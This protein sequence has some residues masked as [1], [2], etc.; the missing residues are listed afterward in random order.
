MKAETL[1]KAILQ[2]AMQGKLVEQDPNDEPASVLLERIKAEK[3]QLIKDGKIKKEK[4][5][6]PISEDE[7]PYELPNGW[8]WVRFNDA[9]LYSTDYVANGSFASLRN[10][11][12][13]YKTENY[14]ILVKT[15]DFSTNFSTN[16]TYID[17]SSYEYLSKSKLYGG[18]L[19]LSNIGASI[20]KV[21]IIP[22][23]DR[24]MSIAPNSIIVKC[25][26]PLMTTFFKYIILSSYGQDLLKS[27]TAGTA[28]PKFSKTQLR[29]SIIPLPPLAEQ[30]RIVEKLEQILPL[31]EEYGKNEEK[32]SKLNSTLPD[33]IK[34]SILQHAVQGKLVPQNPNEESASEL[35]KRIKAEK[36][37]LIKDGKIKKEKPLP[38]IT[39]DEIPFKIPSSWEWCRVND[40]GV[41]K[42]GP[43]GSALTKKIFVPKGN[44]TVKVYEQKNAI[45]KDY[46]LGEYYI[47]KEYYEKSMKGFTVSSGDIIVSCAGTIGET[48]VMPENIELG[49]I[50][51]ALMRMTITK[52]IDLKYFLMY[53]DIILKR[54]SKTYSKGSAIKNIPPFEIFK[55]MLVPLPPLAEQ[56]RIVT[57]VEELLNIVDKLKN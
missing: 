13:T 18:E 36:E 20:G 11:V 37:Q 38:P 6:P 5:L 15:Q 40:I 31:V 57:K 14:A 34:Q 16:L 9:T 48:Y 7:I 19:M 1:K 39:E 25:L 41:Y 4:P 43:F 3:E 29:N 2:Y 47:S 52:E 53:F 10:N 12:N 23:L 33:K 32:L 51:Q 42:K 45:Q 26:N 8:E 44:D 49:I 54:D 21:F 46:T 56:Q 24:P 22:Y 30:Q 17:K 27:F 50:N 28:M 35:L 55:P